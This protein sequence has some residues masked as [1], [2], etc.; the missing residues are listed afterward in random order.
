VGEFEFST[1]F[2]FSRRT[3]KLTGV[4]LDLSA[5]TKCITLYWE[6]VSKYGKPLSESNTHGMRIGK[7]QDRSSNM[8]VAILDIAQRSCSVIYGPLAGDNNKGL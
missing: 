4:Q 5:P 2:M 1:R 3:D 6:L 7:W 8:T